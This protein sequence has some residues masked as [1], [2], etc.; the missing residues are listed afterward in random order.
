MGRQDRS[1]IRVM[2]PGN[3]ACRAPAP[4]RRSWDYGQ[5]SEHLMVAVQTRQEMI[6]QVSGRVVAPPATWLRP[7]SSRLRR[8]SLVRDNFWIFLF[9]TTSA[10]GSKRHVCSQDQ[11]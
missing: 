2:S 3:H 1:G 7:E 4:G 6:G 8:V 5:Q 9:I 11:S 10:Y